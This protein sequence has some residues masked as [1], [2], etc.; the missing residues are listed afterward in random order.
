MGTL[1]AQAADLAAVIDGQPRVAIRFTLPDV[2]PRGGFT[3]DPALIL[4]IARAESNLDA[5]LVSR[6]GAA[7]LM[8]IMPATARFIA[9]GRPGNVFDAAN[10]LALGERYVAWLGARPA[11]DANLL[12]VLA[13]YNAG[14]AAFA[15]WS[16]TIVDRGDPLL[17]IEAIPIDET[18]AFIP[19]VLT[20]TWIYAARMGHVPA[21]L[22]ALAADRWPRYRPAP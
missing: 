21:S 14:P 12:R 5:R 18:R 2:A 6:A 11:I 17:F 10:N 4:G 15:R 13:S 19:R 22:D 20:Y 3:T 9:A 8:Q 16:R 1:A 7:G